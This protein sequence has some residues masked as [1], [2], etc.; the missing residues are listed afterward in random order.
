M[1]SIVRF[2][3]WILIIA[4]VIAGL[5]TWLSSNNGVTTGANSPVRDRQVSEWLENPA[6]HL[7]WAIQ[8]GQRCGLAPFQTPTSG[9]IG[10]LWDDSFQPGH[11]HAGIDIFGGG[12][13]GDTAVYAAIDGYLTRL[14]EWKSSLIIRIPD[15]PVQ[16]GRQIWTYYTHM[17]DP[18]GVSLVAAEF[19]PGAS[20]IPVKAGTLLGHQGNFSGTPGSPTGVHLHFSIVLDDGQ[21]H[22][23]NELDIRNTL[24]PTPYLGF[25]LNAHFN[26]G[27]IPLCT[28]KTTGE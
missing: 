4:I 3:L 9:Y 23:R 5:I 18:D 6:D 12:Q 19:P 1:V 16:P 28:S 26:S 22:F 15:D 25:N 21:G 17:A 7:D 8:A 14:P 27:E 11:R 13:P 24:D 2:L 10:Y 20:E